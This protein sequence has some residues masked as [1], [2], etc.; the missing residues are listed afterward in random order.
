MKVLVVLSGGLDS[1]V[2]AY[3]AVK[4]YG[5][6]EVMAVTFNYGSK[7]NKEETKRAKCTTKALGI[8][9]LIVKMESAFSGFKSDLLKNG[10]KIPKGHYEEKTMKKT[11]VPFRNG[12][13]LSV[14]A[15]LAESNGA[16]IVI[17]GNHAG[18]HSVY[19]DCRASFIKY[20]SK[21]M[22]AGTYNSIRIESPFC[23]LDKAQI[24]KIG[25]KLGVN[26]TDTYSCY[27]GN[28]IQC[29]E[30]STCYERR[31]AFYLAGSHDKTSYISR[32]KFDKIKLRYEN[33]LR[34]NNK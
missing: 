22:E 12:I 3:Q 16:D 33:K 28:T 19:P 9:H 21:A 4:K 20:M 8:K 14:A 34:K 26:W 17:L 1:T 13:M 11:V 30:C 5:P 31:E 18:D 29:G 25:T 10:G 32:E 6:K 7:H 23:R 2:A 24:V 15:G 27:N